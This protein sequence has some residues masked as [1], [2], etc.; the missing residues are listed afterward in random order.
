MNFS[1]VSSIHEPEML[2]DEYREIDPYMAAAAIVLLYADESTSEQRDALI[3]RVNGKV[4][5]AV[6][7]ISS[8]LPF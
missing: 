3:M 2:Q 6:I 5:A 4:R 7:L 8:F 1:A